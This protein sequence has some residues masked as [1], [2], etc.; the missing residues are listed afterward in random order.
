MT[1]RLPGGSRSRAVVTLRGSNYGADM[2][3]AGRLATVAK[4]LWKRPWVLVG[5]LLLAA[6]TVGAQKVVPQPWSAAVLPVAWFA[7]MWL[8]ARGAAQ[9][10]QKAWS[11]PLHR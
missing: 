10:A 2:G 1:R 4:V 6:G 11:S 7:A 5:W 3:F 9:K 8:F